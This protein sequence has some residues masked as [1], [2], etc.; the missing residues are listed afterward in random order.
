MPHDYDAEQ[1]VLSAA[2]SD[3]TQRADAIN[4]GLRPE[5]FHHAPH[6]TVWEAICE[7]DLAHGAVDLTTLGSHLSKLGGIHAITDPQSDLT[8]GA[9]YLGQLA[10]FAS[11]STLAG[12]Y[13]ADLVALA[14]RRKVTA[15]A[16]QVAGEGYAGKRHG[17]EFVGWAVDMIQ[18]ATEDNNARDSMA[19][20]GAIA[21]ARKMDIEDWW[22]GRASSHGLA[23]PP[24]LSSLDKDLSGMGPG[25]VSF[26]AAGTGVGKSV[27]GSQIA[28]HVSQTLYQDKPAGVLYLT[29]EMPK[30]MVFD[31]IACHLSR[32]PMSTY[33][34]GV[35]RFGG[36]ISED[37]IA[38]LDGVWKT[39]MEMPFLVDDSDQDLNRVRLSIRRAQSRLSK[40]GV[41]LRL[42]VIDHLHIMRMLDA[43]RLDIAIADTVREF[44]RI[45]VELDLHMMVLA[46][47]SRE[48]SK[49]DGRP[50]IT[51]IKNSSSV[52]QIADKILLI[53]RPYMA[54]KDKGSDD[55]KRI[56]DDAEIIVGKHR[57]GGLGVY[58]VKFR[59][60]ELKFEEV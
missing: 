11:Y 20:L 40:K 2:I 6:G 34:T 22:S 21:D 29:L 56:K 58:P 17:D 44:K 23:L 25:E 33:R 9:A 19:S 37:D 13:A 51:D 24:S 4:A 16:Q 26:V 53:H 48:V 30:A 45:A 36:P 28:V 47:F 55:A 18:R 14:T 50:T 27:L 8:R 60:D 41:Q 31:R 10:T 3:A 1:A 42:V 43:E 49:R 46:Q 57:N 32:V 5:H 7:L 38:K 35:G 52:E 15:A 54:H 39:A 12:Q 59:A